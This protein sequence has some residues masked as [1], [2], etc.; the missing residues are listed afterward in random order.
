MLYLNIDILKGISTKVLA[1]SKILYTKI[2]QGK[3]LIKIGTFPVIFEVSANINLLN[4][5]SK[6]SKLHGF[7]RGHALYQAP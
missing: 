7:V 3:P 2:L 5:A 6:V 4:G 1:M